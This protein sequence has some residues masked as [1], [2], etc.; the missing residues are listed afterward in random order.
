M[1]DSTPWRLRTERLQICASDT[2]N[3]YRND[4]QCNTVENC[5]KGFFFHNTASASTNP[6]E[7]I[8]DA[9]AGVASGNR[10][11]N[12]TQWRVHNTSSTIALEWWWNSGSGFDYDPT[13]AMSGSITDI[14]TGTMP[15][16]FPAPARYGME[17]EIQTKAYPNPTAGNI[18]I[19]TDFENGKWQLFNLMGQIAYE[20]SLKYGEN[21]L[22]LHHLNPGI[23]QS[24][25]ISN[26]TILNT[27]KIVITK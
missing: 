7:V 24:R 20:T 13:I 17:E 5:K 16:C 23:Y 14:S 2:R 3:R 15:T 19:S 26:N 25:I 9:T 6:F 1:G 27:N 11:V 8:G 21:Q 22:D 10:W 4:Q 12:C 18:T